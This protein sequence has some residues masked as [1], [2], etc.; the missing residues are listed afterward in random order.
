MLRVPVEQL[1]GAADIYLV[2]VVGNIDHPGPNKRVFIQQVLL[3]PRA[4]LG[5]GF[6]H[7]PGHPAFAVDQPAD[8]VL[9]LAVAHH[10]PFAEKKRQLG[11]HPLAVLYEARHSVHEIIKV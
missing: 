7:L 1:T 11:G 9:Q 3:D 4:S 6:R 10:I 5:E 2:M 8:L